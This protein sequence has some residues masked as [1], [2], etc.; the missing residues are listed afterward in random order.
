[1]SAMD[2]EANHMLRTR[3]TERFGVTHPILSGPMA[4][5]T[6]GRLAA[7]VSNTGALGTFGAMHRR[8]GDA[9]V[10]EQ[11]E[12]IRGATDRPFGVGFIT[13][14]IP[15]FEA[16]WDAAIE[17]RVPV[18]ALSFGD[19]EPWLSRAHAAG[20]LVVCQVQSV[21]DARRALAAGADA[22]A[23]QGNEAGGHTGTM[24]LLPLLGAVLDL[25][26]DTPVLAAGGVGNGR[27]LAGVL[28]MGGDGAW[29]GTRFLASAE[30]PATDTPLREEILAS[31]GSDTVFTRAYDIVEGRPWP[32]GVGERVRANA[33]TA[34]WL[35]RED[36]LRSQRDAVQQQLPP[37]DRFDRGESKLA[38][39]QSA[40]LVRSVET[41]ADIVTAIAH[42]CEAQLRDTARRFSAS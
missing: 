25:A 40:A 27:T 2:A 1:M 5:E 11:I 18:V 16:R 34:R 19:P 13:E 41:A 38:Y 10:G 3:F 9:W 20:A 28:A 39:G 8:H 31:D 36:E 21:A 26:G 32:A 35:A 37:P 6:D 15:F 7:A 30:A 4:G 24:G 29:M 14:F 33:F 12:L 22:L 23:A 42:D 17:A